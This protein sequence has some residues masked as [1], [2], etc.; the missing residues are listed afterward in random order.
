VIVGKK[1]IEVIKRFKLPILLMLSFVLANYVISEV[2]NPIPYYALFNTF[3]VG[4]V[5]FLSYLIR[6]DLVGNINWEDNNSKVFIFG[7][8]IIAIAIIIK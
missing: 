3:K 2:N 7:C 4:L 6:V 1:E 5:L 8:I